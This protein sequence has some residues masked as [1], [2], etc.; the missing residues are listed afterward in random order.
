MGETIV[1]KDTAGEGENLGF[2]LQPAEGGRKDESVVV[3]L[4]LSALF[5]C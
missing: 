4:K 2:V 3:A 1:H 5:Y